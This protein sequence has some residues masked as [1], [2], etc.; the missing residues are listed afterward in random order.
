MSAVIQG[1]GKSHLARYLVTALLVTL[2][3]TGGMFAYAYTTATTSL[4]VSSGAADFASITANNT[5]PSYTIF[6]TYRGSIGAGKLFDVTPTS[7][8]TGDLQINVYLANADQLSK[9]YGMFLLRVKLVDSSDQYVD[10]DGLEK[11]LTLENGVVSFVSSNM[12]AGTTYYIKTSGGVYR[13]FPWA[14]LTNQTI[15]SPQIT[16]EVRQVGL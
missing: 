2:A 15:Y 10:V 7:G 9:N 4:S 1:A 16:A 12:T 14:Y 11:V 5:V 8:Y 6:G 13:A 3:I